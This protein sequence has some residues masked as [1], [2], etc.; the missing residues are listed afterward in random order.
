[1]K[2]YGFWLLVSLFQNDMQQF[3]IKPKFSQEQRNFLFI[4]G[5]VL[6]TLLFVFVARYKI[7]P[8]NKNNVVL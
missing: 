5:W 6:L 3:K 4:I 7:A 1:M 2:S 8:S